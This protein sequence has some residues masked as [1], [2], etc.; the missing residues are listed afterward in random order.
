MTPRIQIP[1][2]EYNALRDLLIR[3]ESLFESKEGFPYHLA[4]LHAQAKRYRKQHPEITR[5]EFEDEDGQ[6]ELIFREVA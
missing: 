2:A 4:E 1:V 3:V 5:V 6:I